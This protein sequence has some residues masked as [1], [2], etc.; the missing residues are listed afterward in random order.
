MPQLDDIFG[1]VPSL[2]RGVEQAMIDRPWPSP[3]GPL[4][5]KKLPTPPISSGVKLATHLFALAIA[6]R[7]A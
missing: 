2:A 5:R 6:Q 4:W 3:A 1:E 7:R